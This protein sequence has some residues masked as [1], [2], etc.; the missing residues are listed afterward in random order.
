MKSDGL[1]LGKVQVFRCVA[2]YG[3]DCQVSGEVHAAPSRC[4]K[5]YFLGVGVGGGAQVV[6][7]AESSHEKRL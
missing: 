4:Y 2:L 1:D 6:D 7:G 3:T 5:E